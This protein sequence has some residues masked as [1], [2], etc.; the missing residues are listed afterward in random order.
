MIACGSGHR[1]AGAGG[2]LLLSECKAAIQLYPG[3][4]KV[5]EFRVTGM[6]KALRAERQVRAVCTELI[7]R[8]RYSSGKPMVRYVDCC[9]HNPLSLQSN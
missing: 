5:A 1:R 8:L 4:E 6:A 3:G 2:S 7:R 9:V